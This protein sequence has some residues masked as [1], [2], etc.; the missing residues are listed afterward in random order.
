L[1]EA[2]KLD[3]EEVTLIMSPPPKF[4]LY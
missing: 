1:N 4:L 2:Q 3:L